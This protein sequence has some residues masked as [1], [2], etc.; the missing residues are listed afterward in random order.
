LR[1]VVGAALDRGWTWDGVWATAIVG[2]AAAV[3]VQV[4]TWVSGGVGTWERDGAGWREV[5]AA[6]DADVGAARV[7]LSGTLGVG[8]VQSEQSV[9]DEISIVDIEDWNVTD[10]LLNA[11]EII[12]WGDAVWHGEV[13]PST[14]LEEGI[15]SPL[16]TVQSLLSDLEP[17]VARDRGSSGIAN[18]TN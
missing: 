5:T 4:D 12:T 2:G 18:L 9:V 15:N 11:Q 13:P 6:S 1:V 8:A 3:D 16:A 14:V 10:D 17:C 7:E